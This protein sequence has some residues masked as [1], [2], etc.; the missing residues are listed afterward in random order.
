MNKYFNFPQSGVTTPIVLNANMV[1]SIEQT[2]TTETSFF[3]AGAAA[4]DKVTLTH[5]ADSTGV[6]M[7]NFFVAALVDLMSTSYTKAAPTLMPP[8]VVTGLA[9][10]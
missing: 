8:N 6:A 3:Y 10:N 9:W 1:E 5:A 7:Q 4:T 2:S